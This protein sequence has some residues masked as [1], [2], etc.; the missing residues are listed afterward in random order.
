[1]ERT[2][3]NT[4]VYIAVDDDSLDK[5]AKT[6]IENILNEIDDNLSLTKQSFLSGFNSGSA[7]HYQAPAIVQDVLKKAI[8][9][10]NFTNGKFNPATYELL[11][12]WR[13]SGD[14]FD[15]TQ[16]T[17]VIP[18]ESQ[19]A[20]GMAIA[21][22]FKYTSVLDG[23]IVKP[24]DDFKL[25]F[26]GIAKGYAVDKIVNV[27]KTKR[28]KNGYVSVGGSSIYIF[29]TEDDL[30]IIH[31]RVSG[32]YILTVNK[33]TLNGVSLSTSGD[34]VRYYFG[35][36]GKRYSHIIDSAT[37]YPADTGFSSVTVIGKTAVETDAISTA[38]CLMEREE[39]VN[40]VKTFLPDCKVYAVYE[41][42][43][44]IITNSVENEFSILDDNYQIE[45]IK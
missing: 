24:T 7:G 29:S 10:F 32:Q 38:L 35:E 15:K 9:C 41:P 43:K 22:N 20:N 31:P 6:N 25:D 34:Y 2:F 21:K 37:G 30:Q 8:D 16:I 14:T 36:N 13:L 27:L 26:G 17:A 18:Y 3:F 33:N 11:K 40:F 28:A 44:T 12:S 5:Q 23:K 39:L 42:Q 4:N 1:M 19:L 45:Y